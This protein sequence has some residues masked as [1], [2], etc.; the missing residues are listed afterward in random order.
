MKIAYGFMLH[1][2]PGQFQWPYNTLYNGSDIFAI[3]AD[4]RCDEATFNA[5]QEIAAPSRKLIYTRRGSP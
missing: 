4:Q 3:N 1:D 2:D 5:F